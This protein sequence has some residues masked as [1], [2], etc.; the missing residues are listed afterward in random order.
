MSTTLPRLLLVEDDPL[1]RRALAL[2]LGRRFT[3]LLA[4]N[5][6]V[7]KRMLLASAEVEVVLTDFHLPDGTGLEV[8]REAKASWPD[9]VR[10]LMSASDEAFSTPESREIA[11]VCLEKPFDVVAVSQLIAQLVDAG[12]VGGTPT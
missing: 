9:A 11:A 12:N 1:L 6:E 7:A 5:V 10:V 4:P 8:L 2:T 3:L